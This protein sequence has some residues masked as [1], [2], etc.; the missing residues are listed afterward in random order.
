MATQKITERTELNARPADG[1]L[2][3]IVDVSDTTDN[4][5][6]TSKKITFSNLVKDYIDSSFVVGPASATDNALARFDLTTGKLIQDSTITVSDDGLTIGLNSDELDVVYLRR[7]GAEEVG[8]GLHGG[9]GVSADTWGGGLFLYAGKGNGN[10]GGGEVFFESGNGGLNGGDGGGMYIY[11]GSAKG[12]N[13]NG[14]TIELYTGVGFG[15]GSGGTLDLY[16]RGG[17]ATGNGGATYL[18]AGNGGATSGNGGSTT[19]YG[20]KGLAGNGNGG[21]VLIEA[22]DKNG[23]GTVGK[24]KMQHGWTAKGG[25]L[26]F[27]GIATTDKTFTFPNVTGN[28]AVTTTD[29]SFTTGQTITSPSLS[30]DV[31]KLVSTATNDDPVFRVQHARLA[32]TN[33]VETNLWSL[34]TTADNSYLIECR[35]IARRTGG[36]AGADNDTAGYIIRGAFNN[37]SG[38][39]SIIGA[40]NEDMF[41]EDDSTWDI[42]L[43]TSGAN[44]Q[45]N[46]TG[47]TNV[48]IT[49]HATVFIQTISI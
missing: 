21:D 11:A 37:T 43:E 1:D 12:S 5:D 39:V 23:S 24:I 44:I 40:Q 18:G 26:D 9:D 38:T 14:G 22:G 35:V 25:Y 13:D 10:A 48:N 30:T 34:A 6:G 49:W 47:A 36:S 28:V 16:A 15:S 17:G 46:V 19:V 45:L 29:N 42:D 33:A 20:G 3:H 41:R 8:I 27:T 7:T 32:T 31:L 4:A 2:V